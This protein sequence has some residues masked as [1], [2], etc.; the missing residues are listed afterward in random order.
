MT[1]HVLLNN[2][3]HKDLRII[4]DRSAALGDAIMSCIT[5]PAEFRDLQAYYPILFQKDPSSGAFQAATLFGLQDGENLFLSDTGWDAHYLPMVV[6][7][8]PFLI[9][10]QQR[11]G[12]EAQT[13]VHVDMSS[14]RVSMTE[15]APVFLP[16]GGSTEFLDHIAAILDRLHMSAM[17]SAGFYEMVARYDL[18]EPLAVEIELA[19]GSSSRLVGF[20][21]V[22]EEKLYSL[23]AEA[24]GALNAEGHLQ[25]LFMAV[26]SLSNLRDLIERKNRKLK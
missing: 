22:S 8:Q 20:Y 11:P 1:Q 16:Q 5:F 15:G 25:P 19:D 4:T 10:V 9:G 3:D 6:E 7:M 18:L 21:T 2:V 14:A 23:D 12:E 13:V 17:A 26:A 24:L